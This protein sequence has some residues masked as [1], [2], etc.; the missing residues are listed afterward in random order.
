MDQDGFL[1][2]RAAMAKAGQT[3]FGTPS[4]QTL[5]KTAYPGGESLRYRVSWLGIPAGELIMRTAGVARAGET[6][7][8]EI[9]A[10]SAGLLE[11]FYPV[12]DQFTTVVH[13]P[14]RLPSRQTMQQHE[15]RR[16]NS[17]VTNYDQDS[18]A[19]SYRKND[20]PPEIYQLDGPVHNEFSSFFIMRALPFA[21]EAPMIVPTFADK[22]RHEVG[23]SLEGREEME[24]VLG[25]RA[26][27]RVKPLLKFKGLYEKAGNPEVWLTDDQWRIPVR[28]QSKI[29]IGSL[30]AELIEY[31][32]PSGTFTRP[33]KPRESPEPP[34]A[35]KP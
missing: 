23:V 34:R 15:G 19:V 33:E 27:I 29:I 31:S 20:D 28:F 25:K 13:G 9:E 8:L 30:V 17:K 7:T 24:S 18:F 26:C 4:E 6:F 3:G 21:G 35:D 11:T 14:Q 16:V 22:K 5:L 10:K 32:G 2:L 12:R 1:V